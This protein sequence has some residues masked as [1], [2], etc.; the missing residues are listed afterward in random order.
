MEG[1]IELMSEPGKGSLFRITLP[2]QVTS[3]ANVAMPKQAALSVTGV[4]QSDHE[5]RILIADDNMDNRILLKMLLE[6]TGFT[7]LEAKNG[8]E[9]VELFKEQKPDFVWM[10]MRM[11]VMD[12]YEATRTIRELPEGKKIPIVAITAS[13][14]MEQQEKI[15]TAGCNEMV[16]KPY[17]EAWIFDAMQKYLGVEYQYAEP[18]AEGAEASQELQAID[19]EAVGALPK[20]VKKELKEAALSLKEAELK[21]V[22]LLVEEIDPGVAQSLRAL[23]EDFRYDRI[24]ELLEAG[25]NV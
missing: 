22:L 12:G 16:S 13:A 2:V 24:L 17:K 11:P 1:S 14:F 18:D 4:I 25:K 3:K 9:A 21:K 5:W 7:V 6:E 8:K 20:A 19:P 23:A 15:I 10:D